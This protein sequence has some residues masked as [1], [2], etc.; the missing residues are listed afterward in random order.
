[1][2]SSRESRKLTYF[3]IPKTGGRFLSANT[4]DIFKHDLIN[5]NITIV[6][7][8]GKSRHQ[9]FYYLDNDQLAKP[10]VSL[11]NPVD[12]TI[13]H[14]LYILQ[15]RLTYDI[16]KDKKIFLDYI[17]SENS[18][19]TNYQSKFICSNMQKLDVID[20]DIFNISWDLDLIKNRLSK[21]F[22]L[23]KTENINKEICNKI[24]LDCYK[25]FS[26]SPNLDFI[27]KMFYKNY[28][29]NNESK[30]LRKSLSSSEIKIIENFVNI[31]MEV[32]ET[33]RYFN[34]YTY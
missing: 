23:I 30:I 32:Y 15:N 13:S 20:E 9:S 21:V 26:I 29:I 14:Y 25:D 11:R 1:M 4:V 24:V 7:K 6:D 33:Y 12:R 27:N 8:I 28:F 2:G 5:R 16:N 3:H 34:E 31:D 19:L 22:Y 18:V 10:M 17:T